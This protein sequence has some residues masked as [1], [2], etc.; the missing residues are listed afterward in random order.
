MQKPPQMVL[1][2][3]GFS[4]KTAG[5]FC[6]V[7]IFILKVISFIP[8]LDADD[9]VTADIRHSLRFFEWNFESKVDELLEVAT[10]Y[11]YQV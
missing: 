7:Q 6:F 3:F 2:T 4:A 10:T 11:Q 1:Y 8:S 9:V 5:W